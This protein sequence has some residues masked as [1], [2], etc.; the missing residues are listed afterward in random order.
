[1]SRV[2]AIALALMA[3]SAVAEEGSVHFGGRFGTRIHLGMHDCD[4]GSTCRF[5]NF[6]NSNVLGLTVE[7]HPSRTVDVS[8]G[9]LVRNV[10]FADIETLS[11]TGSIAEVQPVD[12]RPLESKILLTELFGADGLDLVAG[13]VR[14]PWGTADAVSPTD[15]VNPYD[16]EDGTGFA[17]RLPSFALG[18][19]YEAS[20]F[21]A[22]VF[23]LPLF[24]PAILPIDAIDVTALGDPGSVF[25]LKMHAG[26]DPPEIRRVETP[27][28]TPEPAAENVQVAVRTRYRSPVGDF[29]LMFY[30][31][32]ESMPQASGEA[33]LSGFQTSNRVDLGV[34]LIY[35]RLMMAGADWRG[36]VGGPVSAWVDV[37]VFFPEGAALTAARSQLEALVKLGRLDE[38]PD[39]IPEEVTQSDAVYVKAVAGID[40]TLAEH[41][42]LNLQYAYGMALERQRG[43]LHHYALTIIR[44][45]LLDDR[46]ELSAQGGLEVAGLEQLGF[47]AGGAVSWLHGD[48]ARLTLGTTF[49]GGQ[50]GTTFDKI[51]RLSN[52]YL[53]I[54]TRF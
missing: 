34:P 45:S 1:M 14:I 31:G 7:A 20:D 5:L 42:Y 52:L 48:A 54:D 9:V 28:T 29:S 44:V 39:P 35:P 15:V 53:A 11:D 19:S 16:L 51:E 36:E 3:G 18:L 23:V 38:V 26:S 10:N 43:D 4:S 2:P 49:I 40:M 17:Q 37:G 46:L 22:E 47:Q 33:R 24:S 6:R 8:G 13:M 30:K 21:R 25:E 50:T 41:L 12:V 32:F 27:T